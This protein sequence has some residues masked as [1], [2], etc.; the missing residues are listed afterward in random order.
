MP[1]REAMLDTLAHVRRRY[2]SAESYLRAA[3]V[4]DDPLS[5]LRARL[6]EEG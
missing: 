6:I 3:G 5:R 2:G 1:A 4:T